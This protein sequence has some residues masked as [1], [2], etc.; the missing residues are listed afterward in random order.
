MPS[1]QL[2]RFLTDRYNHAEK[3]RKKNE[4]FL[5]TKEGD[6]IFHGI[7]IKN[8]KKSVNELNGTIDIK[9]T[10]NT[11]TVNVFVPNYR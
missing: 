6:H 8:I 1:L 2:L 4:Q 10:D 9:Y 7:G 5:T 3:I 11:F